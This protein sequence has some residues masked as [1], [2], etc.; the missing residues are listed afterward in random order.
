MVSAFP[1]LNKLGVYVDYFR[2]VSQAYG[3]TL[4]FFVSHAHSDHCKGL[5][6]KK[7]EKYNVIVYC[8]KITSHLLRL[9]FSNFKYKIICSRM[10]SVCGLIQ[11]RAFRT[12]HC[13][14]AVT[15]VF[16]SVPPKNSCILFTGDFERLPVPLVNFLHQNPID[17][18]YV[19]DTLV[20]FRKSVDN[21]LHFFRT[22]KAMVHTLKKAIIHKSKEHHV[23]VHSPY[24]GIDDILKKTGLHFCL[25]T[26]NHLSPLRRKQL[27]ITLGKQ[28]VPKSRF[29]ICD[30]NQHTA[31]ANDFFWVVPA[32][33]LQLCQ[34]EQKQKKTMFFSA[35]R[36]ADP[37]VVKQLITTMQ[38][39]NN[40]VHV[41]FFGKSIFPLGCIRRK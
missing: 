26:N 11:A 5:T 19:D 24:L 12:G 32:C 36:H 23:C 4:H 21:S 13:P 25:C 6:N 2:G 16:T 22:E 38:K 35:C 10:I 27:Q 28:L 37:E 15:F 14:G 3:T 34:T 20:N 9:Q 29:R 7:L 17:I 40:N 18:A 1:A 39:V 31:K 8:S 33:V 30:T 41:K